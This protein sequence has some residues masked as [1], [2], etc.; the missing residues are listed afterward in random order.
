MRYAILPI[1]RFSSR[2]FALFCITYIYQLHALRG[3]YRQKQ[4]DRQAFRYI[5]TEAF[6]GGGGGEGKN[7]GFYLGR[8]P[9]MVRAMP[10]GNHYAWVGSGDRS[11]PIRRFIVQSTCRVELKQVNISMH[12]RI[13]PRPFKVNKSYQ[14]CMQ[15][16]TTRCRLSWLTN[17]AL[18]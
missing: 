2:S 13:L 6:L 10:K 11:G 9:N 16:V 17:S 15:G 5:N 18:L 3:S 12:V 7:P 8:A 1:V 4:A 14:F